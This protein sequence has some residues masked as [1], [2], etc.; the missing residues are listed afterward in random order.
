MTPKEYDVREFH[1]GYYVFAVLGKEYG[2]HVEFK[3]YNAV[4][5]EYRDGSKHYDIM[6]NGGPETVMEDDDLDVKFK[7][8]LEFE[9]SIKWDGCS[10][11]DF[12]PEGLIHFC[13]MKNVDDMHATIDECYE[14]AER[15]MIGSA[16]F[17]NKKESRYV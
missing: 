1:N 12:S 3:C 8:A 14:I 4:D 16:N 7:D 11:W 6:L 2:L 13:S 17:G 5:A 9:G 10:D 15:L